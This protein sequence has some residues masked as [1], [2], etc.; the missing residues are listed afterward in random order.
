MDAANRADLPSP[1]LPFR[2]GCATSG[3]PLL[4]EEVKGGSEIRSGKAK[5][6]DVQPIVHRS[7]LHHQGPRGPHSDP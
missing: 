4:G 5:G 6:P 7:G 1:D 2:H 3:A